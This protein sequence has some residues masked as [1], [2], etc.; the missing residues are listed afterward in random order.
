MKPIR[1]KTSLFSV[2]LNPPYYFLIFVSY[3]KEKTGFKHTALQ[4]KHILLKLIKL[5]S[6]T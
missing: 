3:I 4:S 2:L 6:G 5:I 1:H